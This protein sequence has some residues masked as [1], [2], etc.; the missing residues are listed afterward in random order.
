MTFKFY[1]NNKNRIG[2]VTWLGAQIL[3]K[4]LYKL[5]LSYFDVVT[6]LLRQFNWFCSA[7]NI[8]GLKIYYESDMFKSCF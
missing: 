5:K 6:I 4:F 8:F 7:D 3:G 2:N 1:A